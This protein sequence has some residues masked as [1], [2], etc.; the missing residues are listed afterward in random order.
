METGVSAQITLTSSLPGSHPSTLAPKSKPLYQT[1]LGAAFVADSL[2][3]MKRLPDESVDLVLTS[4]PYALQFQKE[5]GNVGKGEYVDWF[6]PFANEIW[7]I[8]KPEGSFVLNIGGSY[9]SGSPTRSLYHFKLLIALCEEAEFNLAQECFWY[10][11]AKLPAPAEWVNVRRIRIKDSV[12]YI[13]WLSKSEWPK[14]NNRNVLVPYSKDM[15]RLIVKGYQPKKRPSG[16]NITEKFGREH[17]GAIPPNMLWR[18]NNDSNSR[19]MRDVSE[20][21]LK[22]NPARFPSVLPEFFINLTSDPGDTILDPFAGSNTTG[23]VAENLGRR[24]LAIEEDD[25]YLH[26]SALRFAIDLN[27]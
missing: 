4:P 23:Y 7:R 8:L 14:A 13:W 5:Y 20:K 11:P 26:A 12:E 1:S 2:P 9:N 18:G 10:N 16:H 24:W 3:F 15:E 19:F 22:L 17:S 27:A 25:E 21:G 6:L